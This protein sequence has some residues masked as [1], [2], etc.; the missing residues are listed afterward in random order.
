MLDVNQIGHVLTHATT[1]PPGARPYR[2][3]APRAATS[4]RTMGQRHSPATPDASPTSVH[5]K[6]T[7][8]SEINHASG[9]PR[10]GMASG[11]RVRGRYTDST[12]LN[13]NR[14]PWCQLLGL[15]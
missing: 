12:Q 11:L 5:S 15:S 3:A 2:D 14:G 8:G 10:S 13:R 4:H 1:P 6:S 7:I 9:G